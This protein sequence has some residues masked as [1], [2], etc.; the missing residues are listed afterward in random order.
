[1]SEDA[2]RTTDHVAVVVDEW[3]ALHP[4]LDLTGMAVFA[5]IARLARLAE[6]ARA[7]VYEHH[8]LQNGDVDVLGPLWR[9]R[10][11]LRPLDL[12]RTMLIGSGTLTPRIDRL[13]RLGLLARHPDPEDRRG[14]ILRLTSAGERLVPSVV[15]E[16]LDVENR[17]L[18][19]LPADDRALLASTLGG[20]AAGTEAHDIDH[21]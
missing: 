9:H 11:G 7:P 19:V 3:G 21:P 15:R 18:A 16:L 12:R 4:E 8:G 6:L 14:R 13:E 17:L 10:E 20:L 5:R 1:M 2:E